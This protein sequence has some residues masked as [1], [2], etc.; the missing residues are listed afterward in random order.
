MR[1][2]GKSYEEIAREIGVSFGTVKNH[3]DALEERY[4]IVIYDEEYV[5]DKKKGDS[6]TILKRE[7]YKLPKEKWKY[8]YLAGL[9]DGEGSILS[10][11]GWSVIVVANSSL[12]VMNWLVDNFGGTVMKERRRNVELGKY[13]RKVQMYRWY[14]CKSNYI[15]KILKRCFK[16]LI[17]KK[18][19]AKNLLLKFL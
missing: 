4:G 12:D 1:Y 2:D 17:I 10:K 5:K 15:L 16:F 13:H 18:E 6:N 7:P 9:I 11:G 19:R 8:A 14:I 3:L